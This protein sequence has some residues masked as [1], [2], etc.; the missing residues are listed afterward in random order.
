MGEQGD[1]REQPKQSRV[2]LRIAN[3]VHLRQLVFTKLWWVE[4]T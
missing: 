1:H 4:R 2:V 3:S